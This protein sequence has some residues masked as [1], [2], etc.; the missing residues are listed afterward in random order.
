MMQVSSKLMFLK[1]S[2]FVLNSRYCALS[3][4][5]RPAETQMDAKEKKKK[6]KQ[7]EDAERGRRERRREE[8]RTNQGRK[9]KTYSHNVGFPFFSFCHYWEGERDGWQ[10]LETGLESFSDLANRMF[11]LH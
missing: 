10:G 2:F 3:L 11:A 5:V 4:P 8:S 1:G 9:G 6:H 7:E